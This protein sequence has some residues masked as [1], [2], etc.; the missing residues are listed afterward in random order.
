MYQ[1]E[2]KSKLINL[3]IEGAQIQLLDHSRS[4]SPSNISMDKSPRLADAAVGAW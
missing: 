4:N 1:P 3:S 2:I